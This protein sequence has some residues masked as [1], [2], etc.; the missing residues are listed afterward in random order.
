MLIVAGELPFCD[1]VPH[2]ADRWFEAADVAAC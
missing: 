1:R 2:M